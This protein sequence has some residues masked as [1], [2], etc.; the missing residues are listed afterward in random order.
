MLSGLEILRRMEIGDISIVPF[1]KERLNPNS[2]NLTLSNKL[3]IYTQEILDSKSNNNY[4][5]IIIPEDGYLLKPGILYIGSTNEFTSTE[6][7]V[8]CISGRSSIGRLGISIHITAGFGD[9]GFSGTWTL[10]IA[11][12]QPVIIYPNM[13]I[14]QI[15]YFP[16]DGD[17]S[18]KY[19][20]RYLNQI[21]PETSRLYKSY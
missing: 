16:I 17:N 10:E 19:E 6:N 11:V 13:E 1:K 8:P 4:E 2:Y 14:A 12:I 20:G 7:L 21:D 18:M 9:N 3:K 5:E 15:Y